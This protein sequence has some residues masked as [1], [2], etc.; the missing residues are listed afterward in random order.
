MPIP[1]Y[2]KMYPS[3]LKSLSDGTEHPLSD[4]KQQAIADFG[5]TEEDLDEMLDSGRQSVFNN[6][7]GWC[8]TYLKKAGL[9]ESPSRA[10]F[11]ITEEGKKV[12]ESGEEITNEMLMRYPSFREFFNGKPSESTDHA[13]TETREED[14]EETPEEA[15]DRLQKKMNQLLQDELLQKIHSNTPAF[16]ERMVVELMEKMGYGLGKVTQSS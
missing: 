3:F 2:L 10:R 9:I 7:I 13:E 15:M 12:L 1:Q 4:A 8:R 14:S 16:F 11:V 5:L 6:R